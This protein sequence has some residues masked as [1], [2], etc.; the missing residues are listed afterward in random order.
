MVEAGRSKS[1]TTGNVRCGVAAVHEVLG[2]LTVTPS[3]WRI[4]CGTSSQCSSERSRCVK[5]RSNF[6]MQYYWRHGLRRS[7]NVVACQWWFLATRPT[8]YC[9]R[10]CAMWWRHG[11]HESLR[12]LS[13]KWSSYSSDL[14][15][16]VKARWTNWPLIGGLLLSIQRVG[17][18]AGPQ[19]AQA[20]PRCTKCNSPAANGQ[21]IYTN[22]RIAV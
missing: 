5:P 2:S 1:L 11:M 15:Q 17:D 10:Q 18:W 13:I 19:P 9:N 8:R 6:P 14:T 20:P 16:P 22:H 4:R 21:C 12:R 7:A 3:L